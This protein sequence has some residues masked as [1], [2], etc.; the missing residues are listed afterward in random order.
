MVRK[1]LETIREFYIRELTDSQNTL[2]SPEY[3]LSRRWITSETLVTSSK[4]D[5]YVLSDLRKDAEEYLKDIG[6]EVR[7]YQHRTLDVEATELYGTVGAILGGVAVWTETED[8]ILTVLGG[9]IA[10]GVG[11][12]IGGGIELVVKSIISSREYKKQ[13]ERILSNYTIKMNGRI[14]NTE[15]H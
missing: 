7:R 14:D 4:I 10:F 8:P 15:R 13:M 5:A 11:A 12:V 1:L 2:I 3:E 9:V 6:R